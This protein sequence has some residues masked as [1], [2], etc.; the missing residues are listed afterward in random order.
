M[1]ADGERFVAD[2]DPRHP[3]LAE[4]VAD[5]LRR[6]I[7]SGELADGQVLPKEEALRDNYDVSKP[8]FR[9]AMRILEAEGLLRVR[10]GKLGGAVVHRPTAHNVAY[11]FGQVLAAEQVTI[12]Q[13]AVALRHLEPACVSLCAQRPDRGVAV[14]P[15]L[16][17]IQAGYEAAI[18]DQVAAVAWSREFHEALVRLCGNPPLTIAAIAL[19]RVWSTHERGWASRIA[20]SNPVDVAEREAAGREHARLIDL[21]EAGDATEAAARSA[22]HLS[23]AQRNPQPADGVLSVD[24][25]MVRPP[26][27]ESTRDLTP[28]EP[29]GKEA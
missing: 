3:R 28:T 16:R 10:R 26:H 24:A 2:T 27:S 14:V 29:E 11:T 17:R 7:L 5:H 6:R 4:Q 22:A 25:E 8:T 13:V 21:I 12:E 15:E 23:D 19:E 18:D 9:E 20:E 1:T